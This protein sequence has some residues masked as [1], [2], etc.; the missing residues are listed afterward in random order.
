M[1]VFREH[2]TCT[3]VRLYFAQQSPLKHC[4]L[5]TLTPS[6]YLTVTVQFV[7]IL[8]V[9]TL[10]FGQHQ[11]ADEAP[12]LTPSKYLTVQL[13]IC[14]NTSEGRQGAPWHH[15]K[16]KT[17][18][19]TCRDRKQR[20]KERKKERKAHTTNPLPWLSL[21]TRRPWDA[22]CCSTCCTCCTCSTCVYL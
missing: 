15:K 6:K 4:W 2:L 13:Y 1:C 12:T 11:H 8:Y 20:K 7:Y 17:K 5:L 22:W 21:H 19:K 9:C 14:T 10:Y 16:K 18:K 3:F